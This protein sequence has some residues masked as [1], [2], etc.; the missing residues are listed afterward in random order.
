M[1][2]KQTP[3]VSSDG[4]EIHAGAGTTVRSSAATMAKED[5]TVAGNLISIGEI[6]VIVQKAVSLALS[7]MKDLINSRLSELDQR[8]SAIEGRL[9]TL[10]QKA[11]QQPAAAESSGL[12]SVIGDAVRTEL[13]RKRNVIISG[14]PPLDDKKDAEMFREFCEYNL[15]IKPWVDE[16][17]CQRIGKSSPKKLLVML[18]SEQSA[19]D[20]ISVAKQQL[21]K[22]DK[23]S[24]ASKIFFNQDLS[25]EEAERAYLKR[26]ERRERRTARIRGNTNPIAA[27]SHVN[28]QNNDCLDTASTT[29][30]S[31]LNPMANPFP[32]VGC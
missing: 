6:E 32:A 7:D 19:S 25:P 18:N 24:A 3:S 29:D 20:L 22:L 21:G 5:S 4:S 12:K 11:C 27:D 13:R 31:F 16:N 15:G 17:R 30:S 23:Q 14:L 8:I 10:E 26:K 2:K 28:V 9:N 1:G